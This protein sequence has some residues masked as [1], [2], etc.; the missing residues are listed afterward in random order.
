VKVKRILLVLVLTALLLQGFVF[1][2]SASGPAGTWITGIQVQ[3][4][5]DTTPASITITFYWAANASLLPGGVVPGQQAAVYAD[6]NPIPAKGSRNYHVPSAFQ[7][8]LPDNFVGSAVV[9]S[10]QPVAAILQ[11]A[12]TGSGSSDGDPIRVGAATGVLSPGTMVFAPYLRRNRYDYDSYMAIQNTSGTAATVNITYKELEGSTVPGSPQ[13]LS[14]PAYATHIVYLNEVGILSDGF[15]GTAVITGT[16]PLAVIIN[17][18]DRRGTTGTTSGFESYNG[19]HVGSQQLFL[20]K[21]DV[22]YSGGYQSG[23]NIQNIGNSPATMQITYDIQGNTYQKMSPVIQPGSAWQIYLAAESQSGIPA[24]TVGSGSAVVTSDQFIVAT[25]S[26]ANTNLGHDFIYNAIPEGASTGTLLFPKFEKRY[27]ADLS[28]NG[29]IQVQNLANTATRFLVTYSGSTLGS[30]LSFWTDTIPG[31]A[32]YR[33]YGPNVVG[34]PDNFAGAVVVVSENGNP[35]AG[36]YTGRHET[37]L[38][39]SVNCYNSIPK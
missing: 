15:R 23:I 2:A 14:I 37:K 33:A 8:L 4:Q 26:N 29:G 6:P 13:V 9:S 12:N 20:P 19:F 28:W 16:Q 25:S 36:V 7:T 35:I 32:S 22:N 3:N 21:L 1:G 10:D 30:D 27:T 5:S 17:A 11:T 18:Y 38:G 34:L 31:G 39:D 24:G